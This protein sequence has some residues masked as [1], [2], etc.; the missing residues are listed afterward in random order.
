MQSVFIREFANTPH[1]SRVMANSINKGEKVRFLKSIKKNE[2]EDVKVYFTSTKIFLIHMEG[3]QQKRVVVRERGP[4]TS[5]IA[6]ATR[7]SEVH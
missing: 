6:E 5:L 7:L 3:R 2:R 1:F 4:M